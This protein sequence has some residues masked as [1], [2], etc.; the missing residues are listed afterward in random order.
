MGKVTF[1]VQYPYGHQPSV[2]GATEILGGK[3]RSVAWRDALEV[4]AASPSDPRFWSYSDFDAV[5]Y[6]SDL[7]ERGI[8]VEEFEELKPGERSK[9][10]YHG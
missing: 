1:V 5:A 4:Q 2:N 10:Q 9:E 6:E 3:L 7:L 8:A